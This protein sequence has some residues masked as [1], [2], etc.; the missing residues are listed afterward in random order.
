VLEGQAGLEPATKRLTTVRS[1]L[2]LLTLGASTRTC[3]EACRI[4]AGRPC[5]WTTEA[6]E[7][8]RGVEPLGPGWGPSASPR[9]TCVRADDRDR[10]DHSRAGNPRPRPA[11]PAK[12]SVVDS[13]PCSQP[14]GFIVRF[15]RVRACRPPRV[16]PCHN[17]RRPIRW[18]RPWSSVWESNPASP[19]SKPGSTPCA[20]RS[21]AAHRSKFAI[22]NRGSMGVRRLTGI[23]TLISRGKNPVLCY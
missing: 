1:T 14:T 12:S 21:R 16:P 19:G 9:G 4:R 20:I 13:A 6:S 7:Q 2:E 17:F 8:M 15:A 23:C 18:V 10:T 22:R 5:Y 11:A 3:T